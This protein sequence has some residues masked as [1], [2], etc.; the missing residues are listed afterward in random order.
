MNRVSSTILQGSYPEALQVCAA[1]GRWKDVK[2]N[3]VIRPAFNIEMS[4]PPSMASLV[5]PVRDDTDVPGS[6]YDMAVDFHRAFSP[7]FVHCLA[8]QNRS[9]MFGAAIL[10]ADGMELDEALKRLATVPVF[11]SILASLTRWAAGRGWKGTVTIA[12]NGK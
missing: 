10:F 2:I 11:S 7:T 1:G 8:G 6:W 5:F 4:Y 12:S 3:G 9:V